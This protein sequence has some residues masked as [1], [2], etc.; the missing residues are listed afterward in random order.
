MYKLFSILA[1]CL[2]SLLM[3]VSLNVQISSAGIPD[4]NS[5]IV[6]G[7]AEGTKNQDWCCAMHADICAQCTVLNRGTPPQSTRL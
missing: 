1:I 5:A 6:G 2:F 7:V 3:F 4:T